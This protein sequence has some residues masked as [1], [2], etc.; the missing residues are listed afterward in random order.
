MNSV[1]TSRRRRRARPRSRALARQPQH[2]GARRV[3][4]EHLGGA[5]VGGVV[6]HEQPVRRRSARR[7]RPDTRLTCARPAPGDDHDRA[8]VSTGR[9]R[10]ETVPWAGARARRAH[11]AAPGA[12]PRWDRAL[13][14]RAARRDGRAAPRRAGR[15]PAS[16]PPTATSRPRSCPDVA[17]PRALPLPRRGLTALWEHGVHLWPGGDAVHAPTPLA[18]PAPKRGRSL[19]VTVHDTVPF[20]H[21]ETLTRRGAAWHQAVDPPRDRAGERDRRADR[22]GRR[23]AG[24][25]T[26]RARPRSRSSGTACRTVFREPMDPNL[27]ALMTGRLRLPETYVLAV[28]TVEPRK[29]LDVL[30]QA[31]ARPQAPDLPLVVVGPRGWGEVDLVELAAEHGFPA[32]RLHVLGRIDDE[33]LSAVLRRATVLAVPSRAE[34]FGLPVLEAMAVGTPVVHTDVPALV[35]VAGGTGLVVPQR[36]RGRA[37][38]RAARGRERAGGDGRAGRAGP[39]AGRRLHVG[40][41]RDRAVAVARAIFRHGKRALNAISDRWVFHPV[42]IAG[43]GD[44]RSL[45]LVAEPRVLID[46][47]AVPAD[48]GGVGRYVDSLVYALDSDGAPITVVCQPRDVEL[49]GRLAPKLADRADLGVQRDPHRP[50]DVGADHAAEAGAQAGRGRAALAALHDRAGEPGGVGGD[51]ARRDVLHRRGAAPLDQGPVLPRLDPDRARPRV[52]VRGPVRGDRGRARPG[53]RAPTR[54][55]WRSSST[56]WT[57]TGSTCRRTRRSRRRGRLVGLGPNTPYVAFLGALEPRKNVPALIRGFAAA[58]RGRDEP[59]RA[60]A[61]RPAGLGP[62]GRA[63]AGRRAAPPARDPRRLPAV[64]QPGRLPRRR[65]RWSRTRRSARGSACRCWRPWPAAR[66]C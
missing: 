3:R 57:T 5:V 38:E 11:R 49:Y 47:T 63:R 24:T 14:P 27:A 58:C 29:G 34:G 40:A 37:G 18:P 60:G 22:G 2:V 13:H 23:G 21:P 50:A 54:T 45:L 35:E 65:R 20:T 16:P 31:M 12:R 4:G 36:R 33:D 59:A 62:P 30:V 41:R 42:V 15:S 66:A 6:H 25:S 1:S 53:G 52:A 39:A 46:A 51:P 55:G 10:G 9:S 17:G 28:G 32:K 56:A 19:V 8:C 43:G 48:R 61:G 44:S 26:R 64:R 7:R